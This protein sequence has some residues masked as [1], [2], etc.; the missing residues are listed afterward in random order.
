M[1]I[2]FT[3]E[4]ARLLLAS[5][6]LTTGFTSFSPLQSSHYSNACDYVRMTLCYVITI[7]ASRGMIGIISYHCLSVDCKDTDKVQVHG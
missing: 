6:N 7:K 5:T 4:I 3:E 1:F 2:L